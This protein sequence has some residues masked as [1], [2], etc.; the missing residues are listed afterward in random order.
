MLPPK[1][2]SNGQRLLA[3][4]GALPN[5]DSNG[6][7]LLSIKSL[8]EVLDLS[9]SKRAR[10]LS[11]YTIGSLVKAEILDINSSD[12]LVKFAGRF[13]GKVNINE[14]GPHLFGRVHFCE[15]ADSWL[16]D[17]LSRYQ[18]GQVPSFK[19][20]EMID[21][22]HPN[23]EVHGYI[24]NVSPKGCFVMLSRK[25][26]ARILIS[27]LSDGVLSVELSSKRIDLTLKEN[28][29]S[30]LP[31]PDT[32]SF[33]SLHVGDIISGYV[34]RVETYGWFCAIFLRLS[35][36]DIDHIE[37]IYRAGERVLAKIL[38]IGKAAVEKARS[39]AER[40]FPV[41]MKKER[42]FNIWVAYFNLENAYGNSPEVW[43]CRVQH[44]LKQAKDDIQ[45]VINRA[46]L[47]LRTKKH[48]KF[49]SHAAILQFKCGVPEVEGP[50]LRA[51]CVNTQRE[52]MWSIYLD[53]EIR[54]G[55]HEVIRALFERATCLS[56]PPK[57]M[58]NPKVIKE[59]RA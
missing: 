49:I 32:C 13:H 54:L 16:N 58:K 3:S 28:A 2:F 11:N 19:R 45:P 43:L 50:C 48:I 37:I 24:K 17:P 26:D 5:V 25:L 33:S 20:V 53:Q 42:S 40:S 35:D 41:L 23:M 22:L 55:D 44:L 34:R 47:S 15:V 38:S 46:L 57:K 30:Q 8:H 18:E 52:Q 39:V 4:V 9:T 10:K 56:L 1:H 7:L 29:V 14:I 51:Y 31:K 21:E 12:L 6:R 27:N 59:A 36:D